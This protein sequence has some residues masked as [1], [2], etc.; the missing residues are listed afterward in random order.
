[1]GIPLRVIDLKTHLYAASTA[2]TRSARCTLIALAEVTL[3]ASE[4]KICTLTSP[5]AFIIFA[6]CGYTGLALVMAL[7]RN[8]PSETF[9]GSCGTDCGLSCAGSCDTDS[10]S[11]CGDGGVSS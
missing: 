6:P 5:K 11:G 10:D 3:P 8:P 4:I 2:A 1:M 7:A 9:C